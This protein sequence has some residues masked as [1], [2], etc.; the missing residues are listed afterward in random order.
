MKPKRIVVNDLMQRGYSYELTEPVGKNFD[1]RF[2][3]QLTPQEM[4]ELGVFGGKYMTDCQDEFP[5]AWFKKAKLCHEKHDP[6]VNFFKVNA[7]QSLKEWR[8]N[9][10]MHPDDP[11]GWFQWY[12]R[13]YMGRR[14]EDDERQIKRWVAIRRHVTQL[15]N[16]CK[17]GDFSCHTRQRQALLHWAVDSRIL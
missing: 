4:L 10:W 15:K 16:A 1:V 9:N 3:P 11:R 2:K 17:P 14:H 5:G 12:C 7:S 8:K 6:K 13:Y